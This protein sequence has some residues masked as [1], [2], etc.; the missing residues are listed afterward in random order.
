MGSQRS[1]LTAT[2][3]STTCDS[4]LV[5]HPFHPLAGRQLSI[6]FERRYRSGG[7]GHVYICDGAEFGNVTLPES[8]TDRGPV[9]EPQ[10]LSVEGLMDLLAV[11]RALDRHLTWDA[12]E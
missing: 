10:L 4:L 11:M 6:L 7:L 5:T 1:L 8:F 3:R 9:P 12:R 2:A